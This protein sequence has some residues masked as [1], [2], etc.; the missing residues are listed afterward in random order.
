[1]RQRAQRTQDQARQVGHEKPFHV[2]AGVGLAALAL[3]A[4]LRIWRSA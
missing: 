3:G 4:G 1:M 2:L